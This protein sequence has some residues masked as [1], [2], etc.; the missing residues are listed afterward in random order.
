MTLIPIAMGFFYPRIKLKPVFAASAMAMSSI[1]VV[2]SSLL[3]RR[4]NPTADSE[5]GCTSE[6][7]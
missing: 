5:S 2:T 3:L 6:D 1:T 4:Y 7:S